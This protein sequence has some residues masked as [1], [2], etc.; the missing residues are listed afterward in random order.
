MHSLENKCSH[1][2]SLWLKT[3]LPRVNINQSIVVITS[4]DI[5]VFVDTT[6]PSLTAS[7]PSSLGILVYIDL[8]SR[9][10]NILSGLRS[11][12]ANLVF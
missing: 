5:L 6:M 7:I 11:V 2:D 9:V 4:D 1:G 3:K 10:T 8:T 12:V